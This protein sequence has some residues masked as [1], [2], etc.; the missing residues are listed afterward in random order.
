MLLFIEM[1]V[2]HAIRFP[3][4]NTS[5]VTVYPA[6]EHRSQNLWKIS[7][8]LMLLFIHDGKEYKDAYVNFNT[9]HVTVY[10]E[11]NM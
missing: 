11:L 3:N 7:I 6:K 9:S 1:S 8:H 5:H 10:R 4:F 2:K